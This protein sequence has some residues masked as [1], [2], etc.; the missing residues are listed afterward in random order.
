ME[1]G[2]SD[3]WAE[4]T[5]LEQLAKRRGAIDAESA[6]VHVRRAGREQKQHS[7]RNLGLCSSTGG[8]VAGRQLGQLALNLGRVGRHAGRENDARRNGVEAHP[9]GRPLDR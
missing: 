6:A 5:K 3:V 9:A 4:A 7:R 1:R 8:R 2:C